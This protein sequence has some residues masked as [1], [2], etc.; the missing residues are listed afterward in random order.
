VTG[1]GNVFLNNADERIQP[2]IGALLRFRKFLN[3]IGD[4]RDDGRQRG[5]GLTQPFVRP[6]ELRIGLAPFLMLLLKSGIEACLL[7]E[8]EVHHSLHL[9]RRHPLPPLFLIMMPFPGRLCK[10]PSD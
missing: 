2:F 9:F 5:L 10:R 1:T 4:S 6:A 3:E 8:Q 7:R